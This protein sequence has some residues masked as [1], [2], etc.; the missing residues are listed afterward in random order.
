MRRATR[1]WFW[2][3]TPTGNGA[4]GGGM[5]EGAELRTFL[6]S[7]DEYEQMV[8]KVGSQAAATARVVEDAG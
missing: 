1:T 2:K 3:S 6:L 7:L 8:H 4:G 5:L